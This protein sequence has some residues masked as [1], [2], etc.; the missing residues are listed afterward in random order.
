MYI[1]DKEITVVRKCPFLEAILAAAGNKRQNK[2]KKKNVG[3][4]NVREDP[5]QH[6]KLRKE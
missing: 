4:R 1:S 3:R 6:K 5:T 2:G